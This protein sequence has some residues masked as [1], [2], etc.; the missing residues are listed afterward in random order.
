MIY[1]FGEFEIDTRNFQL[2]KNGSAVEIEPKVFDLL[3][4]LVANRNKLVTRDELFQTLW[5][6]QVVSDTSLS[7]QIK[8]ARKAI[9][10]DGQAQSSIKTVHGR[11]YQ[12]IVA[13]E[14]IYPDGCSQAGSQTI[15]THENFTADGLSIAVLP[16]SN[17]CGD[18]EKEYFCDGITEDILT[19]L[20][21]FR[22]LLV[23]ARGSA[24]LFK[25]KAVDP[26]H[27][28][29]KLGVRYVLQGSVRVDGD[30]VRITAQLIDGN[31]GSHVWAETYDRVLDDIFAVQDDVTRIIITTL[32]RHLEQAGRETAL[33][34]SQ[35]DLTVSDLLF[36]ARH[37]LP[38]WQGSRETI[39]KARNLFEQ[40][41]MID[42]NCAAAY[43]GLAGTYNLEFS[44]L[45]TSDRDQAGEN[46]FEFARKALALDECDS[47]AHLVLAGAYR[48]ISLNNS[49]ARKH[50]DLAIHANPND[51]W[52]YCSKCN[53]L[54]V[55]GEYEESI[56]CGQ[57]AIRRSPLLPD[58]CL[59]NIG[60]AEYL[61]GQ[62]EQA[63]NSFEESPN[64]E[65]QVQAY[66]AACYAQLK[67][68]KESS[69]A[70]TRFFERNR[71]NPV[72]D[73]ENDPEC[74]RTYWETVV[75]LKDFE[76]QEH[77]IE[78]LRKARIVK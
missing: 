76:M 64:P 26:I 65:P 62:Y 13:T 66:I 69:A 21:C 42:P 51:Y 60:L 68:V 29:A 50:L 56:S 75:H 1:Q 18:S 15:T 11:G 35:D 71:E 43:S 46:C 3:N 47:N 67:R 44:S 38:D 36:R 6:G 55:T 61:S 53:L 22:E 74:W 41:V 5:S 39:L 77:L 49:L 54:T 52:A 7:N 48:D 30:Q 70:A 25:E 40:A 17:M 14:E 37:A 73:N 45:W 19:G 31:N 8:A 27:A 78:G 33:K 23:I 10:D 2:S 28:A 72:V 32:V 12:F 4:Y 58:S 63:L 24:F 20:C 57:E 9:G 34:K 59:R 16:F